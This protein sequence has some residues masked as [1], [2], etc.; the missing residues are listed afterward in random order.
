MQ[1][2]LNIK[3]VKEEI[4]KLGDLQYVKGEIRRLTDEIRQFD[5]HEKLSPSA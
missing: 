2:D 1:F 3:K 4:Q 5:I